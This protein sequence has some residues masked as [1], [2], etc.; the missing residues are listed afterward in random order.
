MRHVFANC[1]L[2]TDR[3]T[4][5][6]SGRSITVE[7][8]VFDLIRLLAENPDRVV[9]RDEMIEVVWKGRIVSESAIS[10]RIAAARKA[11]GDDG[12][13]QA[14]IRTVARRGLQ[15]GIDRQPSG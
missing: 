8:Q 9:T 12:K 6:R 4:L 1:E 14:V 3:L 15:R 5:T 2:D 13:R 7:P 10:A 11:V